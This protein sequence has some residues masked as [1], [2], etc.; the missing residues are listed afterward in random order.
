MAD[1]QVS[2]NSARALV[3]AVQ[4]NASKDCITLGPNTRVW[5]GTRVEA[6]ISRTDYNTEL[7]ETV[8]VK[9]QWT[10][11]NA[12]TRKQA[13][14]LLDQID[15]WRNE[16][17]KQLPI[18][19]GRLAKHET[20]SARLP[21][22][23]LNGPRGDNGGEIKVYTLTGSAEPELTRIAVKQEKRHVKDLTN[24]IQGL[25]G[26]SMHYDHQG[27]SAANIRLMLIH[28]VIKEHKWPLRDAGYYVS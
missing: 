23:Y 2:T 16:E 28:E 15:A 12:L 8:K 7:C 10:L 26:Q 3:M 21:H 1:E 27:I 25:I 20:T 13:T 6:Q 24:K 18:Q 4:G 17:L 5:Y 9:K 14:Q 22:V 19:R 11:P